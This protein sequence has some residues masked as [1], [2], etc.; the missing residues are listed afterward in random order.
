MECHWGITARSMI[1][2][3]EKNY[4]AAVDFRTSAGLGLGLGGMLFWIGAI[5]GPL[6]GTVAGISTGLA[7]LSLI[8]PAA[9]LT[10]RLKWPLRGALV[11]PFI[12]PALFYAVLNSTLVTLRQGGVRWRERFYSLKA[13]RNGMVR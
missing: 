7:L 13:L 8:L 2:I 11:T 1:K 10:R 6:T 4:F 3:M 12:F 9:V 5:I